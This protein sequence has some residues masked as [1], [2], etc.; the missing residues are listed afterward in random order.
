MNTKFSKCPWEFFFTDYNNGFHIGFNVC[1]SIHEIPTM[2]THL[3]SSNQ[4]RLNVFTCVVKDEAHTKKE[5][6]LNCQAIQFVNANMSTSHLT[7]V[8]QRNYLWKYGQLK[9][10]NDQETH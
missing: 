3:S 1:L 5:V 4:L 8:I 2:K 10:D 7:A 6:K 9:E